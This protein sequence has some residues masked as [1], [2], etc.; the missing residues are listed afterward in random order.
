MSMSL[1]FS[2]LLNY[3]FL[4]KYYPQGEFEINGVEKQNICHAVSIRTNG[5]AYVYDNKV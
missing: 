5:F 1:I 4:K 3:V 2:R